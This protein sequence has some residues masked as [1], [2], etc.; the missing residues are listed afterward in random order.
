MGGLISIF[1]KDDAGGKSSVDV[2]LDFESAFGRWSVAVGLS[3]VV[4]T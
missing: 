3:A 2:F 1:N 4:Q